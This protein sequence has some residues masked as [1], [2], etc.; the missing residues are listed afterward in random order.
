MRQPDYAPVHPYLEAGSAQPSRI[1]RQ[2]AGRMKALRA[3]LADDGR[4]DA[5]ALDRAIVDALRDA[6]ARTVRDGGTQGG[7]FPEEIVVGVAEHL[8]RRA[9]RARRAGRK[10]VVYRSQAV[11]DAIFERILAAK[12]E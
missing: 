12:S 8:R 5:A 4:P 7:V 3:R 10:A 1:R 9:E 6:I 11:G 2:T